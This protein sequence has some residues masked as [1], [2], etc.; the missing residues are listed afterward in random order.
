MNK[1]LNTIVLALLKK[2][3]E[4]LG[5]TIKLEYL[6]RGK[7]ALLPFGRTL[8]N[9]LKKI[10]CYPKRDLKNICKDNWCYHKLNLTGYGTQ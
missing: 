7:G 9:H 3:E 10:N 5:I 8:K 2:F 4:I 1:Y 6:S